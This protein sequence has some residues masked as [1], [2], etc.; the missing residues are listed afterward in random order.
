VRKPVTFT[1]ISVLSF[2][3]IFFSE[4]FV[5]TYIAKNINDIAL[6]T[7]F[8]ITL[9]LSWRFN[10]S[11]TVFLT[12]SVAML[13]FSGNIPIL[14]SVSFPILITLISLS[15]FFISSTGE[16]GVFSIHG[17]KKALFIVVPVVIFII[18]VKIKPEAAAT[19]EKNLLKPF[20][21]FNIP[22]YLLISGTLIAF[23][24]LSEF[25]I[26]RRVDYNAALTSMLAL[27]FVFFF[28]KDVSNL[29]YMASL[30]I[31]IAAV[32]FSLYSLSYI[33]ELTG[34]PA[35]RAYNEFTAALGKKYSIAM[36]D[37]DHFKKFNDKY[38]HDTGDEVL[39]LV[40]KLLSKVKGGGKVFR[41][42]G[43]EFVIVF[44][45]KTKKETIPF[46][47]EIRELIQNTPFTVRNPK[48]RKKF[49]KS[50]KKSGSGKGTVKITI[51]I[52][53][54]DSALETKPFSVMKQADKAL[55]KAKKGG[56]N[57]VCS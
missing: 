54:S 19:F 8:T 27:I 24:L 22:N 30:V 47:E 44:N 43:E 35:R 1:F 37:I 2:I 52:G 56:R 31:I 53:V 36:T 50:G 3:A 42:G 18:T 14:K 13:V 34:L 32:L 57:K 26:M 11:R 5:P 49:K 20:E 23:C 28:K 39:K 55:Y 46:L 9:V 15:V 40:A 33:D 12:L 25:F 7:G 16:R 38:G 6:I 41:F 29:H 21:Y 48:S 51:S 17:L 4:K 45:G 10:R